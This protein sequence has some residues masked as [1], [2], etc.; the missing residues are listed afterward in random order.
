[1]R[2]GSCEDGSAV[3]L[4]PARDAFPAVFEEAITAF[5]TS[6]RDAGA[7]ALAAVAGQVWHERI[8]RAPVVAPGPP[9]PPVVAPIG[10]RSFTKARAGA[11]FQRDGLQCRYCGGQVMPV[12][13]MS[14]LACIYPQQL[15]FVDT[16]KAVHPAFWTRG[17]EAD[18]LV[19]GARGGNWLD[20][21]NHVTACARC[22][23]AKSDLT[24]DEIGWTLLPRA[25]SRWDGLTRFYEPLW[26]RAGRPRARYHQE[27]LRALAG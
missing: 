27:W 20:P 16:Y 17:A 23:T 5:L 11:T 15:P 2:P 4:E 18:H 14:L 3:N 21:E 26:V 12:A 19:P 7:G 8:A 1:M 24:L 6:G 10:V 13:L 9:M 22:N 25:R